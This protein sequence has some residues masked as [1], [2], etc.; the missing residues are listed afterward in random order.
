VPGE[1]LDVTELPNRAFDSRAQYAETAALAA[2]YN[3][4]GMELTEAIDARFGKLAEERIKAD[5]LRSLVWLPLGRVADMWL[6]PRVENLN[7]D[8]DWWVYSHHRRETE[9]SW[10]YAGLN[11]V[12]LILGVTG[13][14][15]RP[16]FWG[17]LV[18]YMLLRSLLLLTIEAPET[19]YTLE[20]FP[21][22]FAGGGVAIAWVIGLRKNTPRGVETSLRG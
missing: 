11:A 6:R 4:H 10:A 2:D 14:C 3:S 13:L 5:P 1:V 12:Y 16:R 19:R 20:C 9:F 7:I 17:A 22:L 15:L 21:M 18:V 8:L